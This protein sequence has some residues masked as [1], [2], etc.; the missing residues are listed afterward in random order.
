MVIL[1]VRVYAHNPQDYNLELEDYENYVE[2]QKTLG[3]SIDR[4]PPS[5]SEH[6]KYVDGAFAEN[7]LE[8]L[9]L[10][11]F[12]MHAEDEETITLC[13]KDGTSLVIKDTT[14]AREYLE[15]AFQ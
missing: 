2:R 3:L 1:K 6:F 14:T 7:S 8:K 13:F 5:L 15:R 11:H 9:E 12:L 4:E 10:T